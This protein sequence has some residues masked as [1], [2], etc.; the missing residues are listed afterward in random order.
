MLK[1]TSLNGIF[2]NN[3]SVADNLFVTLSSFTASFL[4]SSCPSLLPGS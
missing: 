4:S 2:S 3:S 1:V